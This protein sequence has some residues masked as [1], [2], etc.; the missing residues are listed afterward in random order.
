MADSSDKFNDFFGG[1]SPNGLPQDVMGELQSI[2]R[3]HSIPPQ[4]LFY[5]W[6]SY[7][8]KMGAE[9]TVLNLDS[10]RALKR[11]IQESLER[12]SRGKSNLRAGNASAP[13]AFGN[14]RDVFGM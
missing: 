7:C 2:S 1:S 9:E 12:E 8:L 10:A 4:E 11:D 3:L 13:R 14:S 6:E 5:K